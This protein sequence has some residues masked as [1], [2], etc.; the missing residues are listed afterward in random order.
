MR[1]YRR[2]VRYFSPDRRRVCLLLA[3]IG[4]SVGVALLEAW[5]VAI[6]VDIVLANGAQSGWVNRIVALALP[7]SRPAQI[8]ALALIG[9]AIQAIGYGVWMARMVLSAELNNR[10]TARVRSDLFG[11]LQRLGPDY[12]KTTPKGDAT[13]RLTSDVAGPWGLMEL[14]VGTAAAAVTLAVM[15]FVLLMRSQALTVAAYSVGPFILASNWYFGRRIYGCSLA[16]RRADADLTS[17][18]QQAVTTVGL[19]QAF[20]RET[21]ELGRHAAAVARRNDM[22]MRLVWQEQF[23]PFARDLILA[24][25]AAAIT[26]YG[27]YLVYRD[28][29]LAPIPDGMTVGALL[30]F[31]DYARKLWDPLKW[32]TEFVAKAQVH[33]AACDRVFEVL[34]TAEAPFERP[35][36]GALPLQPRT[37][38][39]DRVGF[40]YGSSPS[41]LHEASARI[42]RGEMVAFVGPS[43]TGKSTLLSLILRFHDPTAGAL[44]LDGQDYRDFA[45]AD[46][47]RHFAYVSQDN[48]VLPLSVADNIAYGR[49]GAGR[50]EIV[51]AAVM[52]GADEF[53]AELP[54]GYDTVL[55]EG[56]QTLSG[57]QR[58]RIAIARAILSE[59][60]FLVLDEPTSALDPQHEASLVRTLHALKGRRT[61]VMVTH[62]TQT[63]RY[64]DTVFV[65]NA[66]RI[67][68]RRGG[69]ELGRP[70]SEAP[71]TG[72]LD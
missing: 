21:H 39:L 37:L 43:G 36:A 62:R 20:R 53:V 33:R 19:T 29:V 71:A 7:Q 30:V 64:C 34:D 17:F 61:I 14:A 54:A 12:H 58:Q 31:L 25:S 57:G 65:M 48:T 28:T 50:E 67:V 68:D 13:F 42:G 32:V 66:G 40:S 9:M 46:I 56:G 45:V 24:A 15:T 51:N 27:G 38:H 1:R 3:L 70:A 18:V 44:R 10:G 6:L 52:A 23:Y 8:V 22:T 60:P 4:M 55:A 41:V 11:K 5:P 69:D 47:R 35:G 2:A 49:P 72:G 59:A 63:T 26:G 16:S